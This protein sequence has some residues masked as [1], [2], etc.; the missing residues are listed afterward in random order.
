MPRRLTE[1]AVRAIRREHATG[2]VSQKLLGWKYRVTAAN[3][4]YIVNRLTWK[5][6]R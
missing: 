2:K 4:S 1:E 6:V 3:I 5:E